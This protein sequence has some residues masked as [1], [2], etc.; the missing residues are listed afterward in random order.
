[1]FNATIPTLDGTDEIGAHAAGDAG[2]PAIIV[3]QEIFGVNRG[4]RAKCDA[5]AAEGYRAIAPDLFWRAERGVALDPDVPEDF[6]KGFKLMGTLDPDRTVLDLEAAMRFAKAGGAP[7]VGVVGYCFGGQ[8]AYLCAT[9]T[10][11]D[12]SVGYYGAQIDQ[13][14]NEAHAIAR[15][16]LLHFAENDHFIGPEQRAAV[17]AG[18][19][20]NAHVVIHDYPGVDHGFAT[21]FGERRDEAAAQL[22]DGRTRDFFAK[23]LR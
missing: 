11:S 4:I 8:M 14:L 12:A 22:A 10:D 23:W 13:R 3:I 16:L 17:H 9:R 1:M 15:P 18:L 20:G 2:A 7:K 6:A 21:Q 19:G 5:L